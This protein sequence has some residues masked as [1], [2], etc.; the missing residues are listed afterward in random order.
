[1]IFRYIYY[2]IDIYFFDN[3]NSSSILNESF[4]GIKN[5]SVL[6]IAKFSLFV[7]SEVLVKQLFEV[8][9]LVL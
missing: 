2:H 8:F 3:L 7:M 9:F 5:C 4:Q 1:M 6:L